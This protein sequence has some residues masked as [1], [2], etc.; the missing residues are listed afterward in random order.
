MQ[1][2]KQVLQALNKVL[3]VYLTSINQYF[4]HARMHKNWGFEALGKHIFAESIADMKYADDLIERILLLEGLP[5]LQE[6]GKI[7]IG[8]DPIETL[9]CDIKA[10]EA[11]D[12]V[13]IEAIALAEEKQDYVSR[14]LLQELKDHNE[15]H[16]D[17]LLLQVELIESLGNQNYLQTVIETTAE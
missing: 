5:N 7:F 16:W 1:G 8:E 9:S 4:L 17:W 12:S 15:D 11:K 13:L 3:K 10:E 6:L 14:A 2:D